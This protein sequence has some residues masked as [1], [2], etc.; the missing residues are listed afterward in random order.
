MPEKT[1]EPRRQ[2]FQPGWSGGPGRPPGM[3]NKY[4]QVRQALLDAFNELQQ[5]PQNNLVAWAKTEPTEF[6]RL[7]GRLI[8]QDIRAMIQEKKDVTLI[9]KRGGNN[10]TAARVSPS[11]DSGDDREEEIQCAS[12]WPSLGQNDSSE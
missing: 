7:I 10:T 5:D 8:P 6:Y 3:P 12:V 9:I 1:I 11:S 4:T 2:G